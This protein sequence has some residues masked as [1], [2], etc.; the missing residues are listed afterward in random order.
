MFLGRVL[1]VVVVFLMGV[2][3]RL[4]YICYRPPLFFGSF[5][6]SL[7]LVKFGCFGSFECARMLS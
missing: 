2:L 4:C 5:M 6:S 1:E 3:G 7:A